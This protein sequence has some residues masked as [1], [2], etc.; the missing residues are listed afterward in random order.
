MPKSELTKKEK[1]F[2]RKYVTNDENASRAVK[3]VFKIKNDNYARVKGHRLITRDNVVKEIENV[4]KTIADSLPDELLTER[5]LELL[6]KR[7]YSVMGNEDGE[8]IKV[9]L[10]PDVQG[11]SKGLDMAYKV[12]GTYAPEKSVA[13]KLN[14]GSQNLA[15][16]ELEALRIKYEEELKQKLSGNSQ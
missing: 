3:E 12:K 6:N 11:V 5:H 1:S 9:D 8:P 14:V 16:P 4:K 7:E 15:N 10:G 2:V 13:L